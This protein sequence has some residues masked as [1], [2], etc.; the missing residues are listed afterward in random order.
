MNLFKVNLNQGVS[1]ATYYVA[2]D[3]YD[4]AIRIAV[5]ADGNDESTTVRSIEVVADF[6]PNGAFTETFLAS[7]DAISILSGTAS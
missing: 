1:S 3:G 7:D 4:E 2:C 5:A 6:G